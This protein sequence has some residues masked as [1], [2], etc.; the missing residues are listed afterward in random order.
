[1]PVLMENDLNAKHG[2]WSSRLSTTSAILLRD[3]ADSSSCLIFGPDSHKPSANL[4]ILDIVITRDLHSPIDL[5]S[6][7]ALSSD[8][9]LY[10]STLGAVLPYIAHRIDL[11]SGALIEPTSRVTRK[12]KSAQRGI[13]QQYGYRHVCWDLLRRHPRGS[14]GFQIQTSPK[15]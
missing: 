14:G 15:C 12:Q 9:S 10:S 13:T 8:I 4:D 3:Y 7:Y 5:T 1:M 2:D 6:C 11:T